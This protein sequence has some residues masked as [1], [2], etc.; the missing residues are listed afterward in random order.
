MCIEYR[1]GCTGIILKESYIRCD[2][3]DCSRLAKRNTYDGHKSS[4]DA[5]KVVK[6]SDTLYLIL[7]T[8]HKN[9]KRVTLASPFSISACAILGF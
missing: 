5:P 4:C 1:Y 9:L 2:P 3:A 7:T 8:M 6:T